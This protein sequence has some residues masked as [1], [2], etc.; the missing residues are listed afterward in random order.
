VDFLLLLWKSRTGHCHVTNKECQREAV[1]VGIYF[2]LLLVE[3]GLHSDWLRNIL[4][5]GEAVVSMVTG[6]R[7][8]KGP[9]ITCKRRGSGG[10]GSERSR[11][12]QS[13]IG[14]YFAVFTS[15]C[16]LPVTHQGAGKA[17]GEEGEQ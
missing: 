16:Y 14:A 17:V 15:I 11:G 5:Y 8:V 6:N 2:R 7:Q 13:F 3:T 9:V 10:L 12:H 1:Y 4:L